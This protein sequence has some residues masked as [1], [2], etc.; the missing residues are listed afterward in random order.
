VREFVD[1]YERARFRWR[2]DRQGWLDRVLTGYPRPRLGGRCGHYRRH[3]RDVHGRNVLFEV[4]DRHE[5][6]I[7]VPAR[8]RS[9]RIRLGRVG[10]QPVDVR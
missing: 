4:R 9:G 10:L 2:P 3:C 6:G 7:R 8:D 1:G 5:R